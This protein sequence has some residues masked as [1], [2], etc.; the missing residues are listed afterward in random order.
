MLGIFFRFKPSDCSKLQSAGQPLVTEWCFFCEL[1]FT[2]DSL[3]DT[4]KLH[5]LDRTLRLATMLR[6]HHLAQLKQSCR[7]NAGVVD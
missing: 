1:H 5:Q 3:G 6:V 2:C 4:R 7:T